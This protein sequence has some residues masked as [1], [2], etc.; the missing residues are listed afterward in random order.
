MVARM[1]TAAER[2]ATAK[3]AITNKSQIS[4]SPDLN[5]K[6]E[7]FRQQ[8]VTRLDQLPPARRMALS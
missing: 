4:E 6:E 3:N 2:M 1:R 8:P 5:L 7:S